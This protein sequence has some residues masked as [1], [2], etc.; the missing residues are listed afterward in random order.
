MKTIP[1]ARISLVF[2]NWKKNKKWE[3]RPNTW[4]ESPQKGVGR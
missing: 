4:D 2:S 1:N 3:D